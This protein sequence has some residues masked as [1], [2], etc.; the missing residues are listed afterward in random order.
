MALAIK[1]D[2]GGDLF[3]TQERVGRYQ[4]P[5][6]I[7]KFRSM[8]GNDQGRYENGKSKLVVTRV[9]R[10]LRLLRID[11]FPQVWNILKGDLSFVG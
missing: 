6:H 4:K 10:W 8:S 2:D 9:G 1:L 7:W 5:I 3:I 11:E